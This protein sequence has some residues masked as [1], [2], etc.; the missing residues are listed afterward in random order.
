MKDL[1]LDRIAVISVL[2]EGERSSHD[3]SR[4]FGMTSG[5]DRAEDTGAA[6][7]MTSV[8][9]SRPKAN[10]TSDEKSGKRSRSSGLLTLREWVTGG[11]FI[12]RE[13]VIKISTSLLALCCQSGPIATL[14]TPISARSRSNGSMSLRMSPLFM[15]VLTSVSIAAAT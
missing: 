1:T 15:A 9:G 10:C 13:P 11:Y 8:F 3:P 7:G 4:S 2:G 6:G 12:G 5:L 14:E